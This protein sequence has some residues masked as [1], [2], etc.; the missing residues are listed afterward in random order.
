MVPAIRGLTVWPWL[1]PVRFLQVLSRCHFLFAPYELDASPRVLAEALC[2]D[3]PLLVYRPILGGWKYVV[4]STG[5]F[6]DHEEEVTAAASA[7]MNGSFQPR[8]WY[9]AQHGPERA[10]Q[11]LQSQM[12]QVDPGFKATGPLRLSYEINAQPGG[13]R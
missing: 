1:P 9:C 7:C 13:K 10:G 2:L 5:V 12:V 8:S 4:P 11:T 3:V 6:F